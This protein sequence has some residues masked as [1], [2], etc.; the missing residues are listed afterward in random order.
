MNF[1]FKAL[2][3][4]AHSIHKR[5]VSPKCQSCIG[6]GEKL[7]F[8]SWGARHVSRLFIQACAARSTSLRC[9]VFAT[10]SPCS[11][12]VGEKW[13]CCTLVHP[14]QAASDETPGFLGKILNAWF[15]QMEHQGLHHN[16]KQ[17]MPCFPA[18]TPRATSP[19][20]RADVKRNES[21]WYMKG[22][23]QCRKLSQIC[24]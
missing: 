13:P 18:A 19:M 1:L 9:H 20:K 12:L 17:L 21:E 11:H 14:D 5:P 10:D 15:Y 7:L 2:G 22:L 6:M 3:A 24:V 16:N 23:L 8:P 4:L